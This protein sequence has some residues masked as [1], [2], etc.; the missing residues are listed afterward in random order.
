[1]FAII[2]KVLLNQ[3]RN[4]RWLIFVVL[5]PIFLVFL[6]GTIL[7][8][9]FDS[10]GSFENVQVV[11]LDESSGVVEQVMDAIS[12]ATVS[13]AEDYGIEL[14]RILSEDEGKHAVRLNKKIFVHADGD[15]IKTYYNEEDAING[16]RVTGVFQ[17]V[18][19]TYRLIE[20]FHDIDPDFAMRL[21][22]ED[23][24]GYR[25][26]LH[27]F[28]GLSHMTSYDYYGVA[29][30][31]LMMLYLAMIP[32]SDMFRDRQS[33]L[34]SRIRLTGLSSLRYNLASLITYLGIGVLAFIPSFLY[35]I[36]AHGVNWGPQPVLMYLYTMLFAAFMVVVGMY[37]ATV[38]RNRGRIDVILAVVIFP[39]LSFL[40]GSYTPLAP[41]LASPLDWLTLLSPLRW[42][43]LGVFRLLYK[44][45][46]D[47]MVASIVAYLGL[48]CLLFYLMQ[49]R[50]AREEVRA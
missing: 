43:N 15:E 3:L 27:R 12:Q 28:T 46:A 10:R 35:S 47:L 45:T 41:E 19:N 24:S 25:L 50:A 29:E 14:K 44:D 11:V 17:G 32:L 26:P 23:N 2:K 39:V 6:I 31:T 13:V 20:S 16:A 34:R 18:T 8:G 9:I 40:G 22:D 33:G 7:E 48:S 21:L 37:L 1:M 49:R 4:P 42:V 38:L 30:I 36:Y 5:F